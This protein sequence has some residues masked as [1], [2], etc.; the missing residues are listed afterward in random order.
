MASPSPPYTMVPRWGFMLINEQQDHA[1][2]LRLTAIHED[3]YFYDQIQV[4]WGVR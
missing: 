3:T 2:N 1:V 4:L